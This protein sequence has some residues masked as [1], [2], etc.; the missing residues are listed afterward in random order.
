MPAEAKDSRTAQRKGDYVQRLVRWFRRV[1]TN[2]LDEDWEE[3]KAMSDAELCAEY[4]LCLA[5][6]PLSDRFRRVN[7][8]MG[9]RFYERNLNPPN[10]EPSHP[11]S[12]I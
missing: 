2:R 10:G 1:S 5:L 12:T 9:L 8:V 4:D 11:E 6:K 3:L 7:Q